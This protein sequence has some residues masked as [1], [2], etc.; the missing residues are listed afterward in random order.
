MFMYGPSIYKIA[1]SVVKVVGAVLR[2]RYP[3]PSNQLEFKLVIPRV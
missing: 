1:C 2:H 3:T